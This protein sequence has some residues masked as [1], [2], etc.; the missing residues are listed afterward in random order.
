MTFVEA[1][2]SGARFRRPSWMTRGWLVPD[3]DKAF[4]VRDDEEVRQ[5]L[6]IEDMIAD[7]WE[8]EKKP[9]EWTLT[10]G[11]LG[12][13]CRP[14]DPYLKLDEEVRVREVIE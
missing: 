1:L 11:Q 7:D 8:I 5:I 3:K 2:K 9:R 4:I 14:D 6:C 12:L 13:F 10:R